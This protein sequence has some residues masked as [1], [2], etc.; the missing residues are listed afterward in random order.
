MSYNE[1]YFTSCNGQGKIFVREWIP[2]EETCA[3]LL[4][5][6][7]M[8]EHSNRYHEFASFLSEYGVLVAA[9][10]HCGHGKSV[11]NA[12]DLGFFAEKDG[13]NLLVQNIHRLR[14]IEEEAHPHTPVFLLGHSMGSFLVRTYIMEH[15]E[16][17]AGA[18]LCGTGETPIPVIRAG[19]ALAALERKKFGARHRSERLNRLSFGSFNKAF[20][21]NRTNFD[22]LTRD[23][24][25]VDEY[26]ADPYC[27]FIF[28]VS[29]FND[30][31]DGLLAIQNRRS[32]AKILPT[33][34]I[35]L[36]SGAQDPVGN[37][38]R[39]VQKVAHALLDAGVKNVTVKLYANG[40]HEI[41]NELNRGQVYSDVLTWIENRL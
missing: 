24:A 39:G 7:G 14:T 33:L 27:G 29:A 40:R 22:W 34:P 28:T 11:R 20:A 9:L 5:A 23:D 18:L 16:G 8:A 4:I 41:L 32:L 6:H 17:L 12:D 30:L 25:I 38:G 1:F 35:F 36:F 26:A 19:K 2:P 31:F 10:D 37:N 13:W 21:P 15:S 3:I